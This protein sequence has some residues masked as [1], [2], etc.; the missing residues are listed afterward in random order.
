ML[1]NLIGAT[2]LSIIIITS[3]LT[4]KGQKEHLLA[5]H[6]ISL[7]NRH[8][9]VSVNKIFKQNILLNINYL[10]G[11]TL[12]QDSPYSFDFTLDPSE[13]FSFHDNVLYQYKNSVVKTTN[14]HFNIAEGF[15]S[16]G[17]L[18]GDGVCHL[19]S[20]INWVAQD[21]KLEVYSPRN[22]DFA[23]IAE[24]PREYGVSIYYYPGLV[25][26]NAMRNLYV[27]NNRQNPIIFR[28]TYEMDSLR[29]SA[30]DIY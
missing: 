21:A 5:S 2:A 10:S 16:D 15:K 12:P 23:T 20:L 17:Y 30:F 4:N 19:A 24:I 1:T 11:L 14:S 28:F 25:E 26:A 3:P 18:V 13:T 29:V 8:P 6:E 9:V 27:T 22:H 7:E